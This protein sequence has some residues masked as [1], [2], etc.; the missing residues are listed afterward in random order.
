ME[1]VPVADDAMMKKEEPGDAMAK[2]E[3]PAAGEA[4]MKKEESGDAMAQKEPEQAMAKEKVYTA[5]TAEA[6]IDG[7]PKVLFFHAAWCP[8]CVQQDKVLAS[9]YPSA[10]FA[11][12]V[13]KIDYDSSAELK[14]RYGVVQQHTYV[15]VDGQGNK[16]SSASFPTDA[17][18]QALLQG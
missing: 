16:L 14:Q 1:K 18:L 9:W 15:I 12:S 2:Q 6:L 17:D 10:D 5:F 11:Y 8:K 13:F 4:M 7:T 3:E